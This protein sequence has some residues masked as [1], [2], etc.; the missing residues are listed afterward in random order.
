[1]FVWFVGW[2]WELTHGRCY[3]EMIFGDVASLFFV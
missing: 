1:M 2:V 3:L